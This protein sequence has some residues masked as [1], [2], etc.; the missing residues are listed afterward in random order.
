MSVYFLS[1]HSIIHN[2]LIFYILLSVIESIAFNLLIYTKK[3][4]ILWYVIPLNYIIIFG[5][6]PHFLRIVNGLTNQARP[7]NK[8]FVMLHF[9]PVI[10]SICVL[11]WLYIQPY[12][13][14]QH[15]QRHMENGNYPFPFKYLDILFTFQTLIYIIIC[16]KKIF[17]YKKNNFNYDAKIFWRFI[18]FFIVAGIVVYTANFLPTT[19]VSIFLISTSLGSIIFYNSFLYTSLKYPTVFEKKTKKNRTITSISTLKILSS[20]FKEKLTDSINILIFEE[21]I[22]TDSNINIVTFAKRCNVPIY[23]LRQFLNQHYGK[24]FTDFINEFRIEEAKKLLSGPEWQKYSVEIIA[25]MCGFNSRSFFYRIFK[26]RT[27]VS[28]L[29]YIKRNQLSN[30]TL[31]TINN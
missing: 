24:S 26:K 3:Y 9:I 12:N 16:Y 20:D 7:S 2:K 11:I 30:N 14:K 19:S 29:E 10:I 17:K 21:K 1:K 6:P 23:I 25:Q 31:K 15:L 28:P 22:F 27:G 4:D 18:N 13:Y 8:M 5:V